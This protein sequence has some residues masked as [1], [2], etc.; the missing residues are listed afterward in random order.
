MIHWPR[1]QM[2]IDEIMEALDE[3]TDQ[4]YAAVN[5]IFE[6]DAPSP[7]EGNNCPRLRT[8]SDL[9]ADAPARVLAQV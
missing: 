3:P 6:D 2:R 7:E 1:A 9:I 8:A 4:Q 5:A